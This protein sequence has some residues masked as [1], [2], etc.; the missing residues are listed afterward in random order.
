MSVSNPNICLTE[1]L[2]S[3]SAFSVTAFIGPPWVLQRSRAPFPGP[4]LESKKRAAPGQ[5]ALP[6]NNAL[7]S[8]CEFGHLDTPS[9]RH[10]HFTSGGSHVAS[11]LTE[12]Q[13][14]AEDMMTVRR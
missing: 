11:N 1:T 4:R 7:I 10:G 9:A 3:G 14:W 13:P 2:M 5:G 8:G 6:G 12:S